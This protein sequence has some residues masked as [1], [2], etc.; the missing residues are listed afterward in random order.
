MRVGDYSS[1]CGVLQCGTMLYLWVTYLHS[2]SRT[3]PTSKTF[4]MHHKF[5]PQNKMETLLKESHLVLALEA[6]KKDFKLLYKKL[7]LSTRFPKPRFAINALENNH[8]VNYL[9]TLGN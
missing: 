7:P 8:E 9:S 4:Q 1:S 3:F 2:A 5:S 6:F